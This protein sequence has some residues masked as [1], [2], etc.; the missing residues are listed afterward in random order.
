VNFKKGQL[1]TE[2]EQLFAK[3]DIDFFHRKFFDQTRDA[4]SLD[5]KTLDETVNDPSLNAREKRTSNYLLMFAWFGIGGI[6]VLVSLAGSYVGL[7]DITAEQNVPL[8]IIQSQFMIVFV[9][10]VIGPVVVRV[11]KE[12]Y[13]I[14]IEAS[15]ISMIYSDAVKAVN[16]YQK[17]ADRLRNKDGKIPRE[18]Q[19]KLRDLA[20]DSI[21]SNYD[22]KR[23]AS[24]I[25]SVGSQV[26]EKAIE[27]AVKNNWIERYPLEKKQVE[28]LIKQSIDAYP[29]IVEWHRLDPHVK[30]LFLDGHVKRLL[31][32]LKLEGWATTQLEMIFDAEVSRRVVAATLI[33]GNLEIAALGGKEN[34]YLKYTS[35]VMSAVFQSLMKEKQPPTLIEGGSTSASNSN[36]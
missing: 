32:T 1:L 27:S 14:D 3:Q 16:L 28:E 18:Y 29:Q 31:S 34:K 13:D 36:P 24:L 17:E 21:K 10:V 19:E 35:A 12:K 8:Q 25:S 5:K 11:L 7:L 33:E 26:F 15:Q 20:F 2:A 9:G 6:V 4:S 23:Y 22:P 30:E